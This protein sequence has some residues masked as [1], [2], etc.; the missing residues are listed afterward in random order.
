MSIHING[1]TKKLLIESFGRVISNL[2]DYGIWHSREGSEIK[3]LEMSDH[4]LL[5]SHRLLVNKIDNLNAMDDF[6]FNDEVFKLS[7][8]AIEG[9]N[10]FVREI[11]LRNLSILPSDIEVRADFNES[12][13]SKNEL[14]FKSKYLK[15]K[16]I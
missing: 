13:K 5:F 2:V 11:N 15:D 16:S 12:L 9:I 14:S 10:V 8:L 3:V 7:I 1:A 6:N 4:Y